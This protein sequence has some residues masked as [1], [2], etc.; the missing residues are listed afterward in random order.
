MRRT[1]IGH[2]KWVICLDATF[3]RYYKL[4]HGIK[5]NERAFKS[6]EPFLRAKNCVKVYVILIYRIELVFTS[7]KIK[8]EKK[9]K[10]F[11]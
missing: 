9:N 5:N 10:L 8:I 4:K 11:E 2:K 3:F 6:T 7:Y 1:Q